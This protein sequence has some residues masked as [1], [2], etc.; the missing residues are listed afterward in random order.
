MLWTGVPWVRCIDRSAGEVN[1][2][3]V[4]R[5][6]LP[7]RLSCSWGFQLKVYSKHNER[8]IDARHF[9]CAWRSAD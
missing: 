1:K 6:A 2:M 9:A 8:V 4:L 3:G 5:V 7:A